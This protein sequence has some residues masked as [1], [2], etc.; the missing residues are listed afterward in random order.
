MTM[1]RRVVGG[2]GISVVHL[3]WLRKD[4]T[5]RLVIE[6]LPPSNIDCP[7]EGPAWS[8][9]LYL[10]NTADSPSLVISALC[11]WG[12]DFELVE[13]NEG[14]SIKLL[15]NHHSKNTHL[16]R[17]AI[18]QLPGPQ[19]N[20]ILLSS[21]IGSE[22]NGEL[23]STEI[24][25]EGSLLLLPG[26]FQKSGGQSDGDQV[27]VTNLENGF[28]TSGEILTSRETSSRPSSGISPGSKHGNAA[29]LKLDTTE[30]VETLLVA[31]SDVTEGIPASELWGGGT[32]FVI[33]GSV[34]GRGG[35]GHGS[36]GEGGGAGKE[37]SEEGKFHHG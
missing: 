20:H 26:Q 11:M 15:M 16:C 8:A 12:I 1:E 25:W 18:V 2:I 24:S 22:S 31:I 29:V 28:M 35:L 4:F 5:T 32:D 10:S 17:T 30:V 19:V 21:C 34:K 37:G 9:L 3:G 36:G 33:E 13:E 14:L 7:L 6:P 27:L 23:G